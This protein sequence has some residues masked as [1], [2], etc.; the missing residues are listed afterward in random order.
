MYVRRFAILLDTDNIFEEFVIAE[1][2]SLFQDLNDMPEH[3]LM[4]RPF[5]LQ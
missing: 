1:S 2:F 5:V 3:L 4:F